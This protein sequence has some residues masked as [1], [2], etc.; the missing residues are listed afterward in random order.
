MRAT[1]MDAPRELL[2]LTRQMK[3]GYVVLVRRGKPVAYLF[4][5]AHYDEEDIG[6][7][8][9]PTFWKMIRKRRESDACIPLDEVEA[10]LAKRD[11]KRNGHKRK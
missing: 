3:S 6:Y 1:T 10:Q 2:D 8:T 5:A 11:S 9:N 7:M 4:S